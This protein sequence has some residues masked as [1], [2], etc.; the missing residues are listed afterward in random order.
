MA[1]RSID[2]NA[3]PAAATERPRKIA[4]I[5]SPSPSPAVKS[6]A[7]VLEQ[8]RHDSCTNDENSPIQPPLKPTE[9]SVEY[10]ASA[11]LKPLP[12][13][14]AKLKDLLIELESKDW[15][16]ACG[17]LND[18]RRFALYHSSL[19]L[20]ILEKVMAVIVKTMKSPRSALC[21]TSIMTCND[22]FSNLG[23]A[24]LSFG[25]EQE[26]AFDN[27]LL[28]LLLKASQDKR[29]VC[30]EAEKALEAMAMC[31]SPLPLLKKLQSFVT[32]SNLRVRAKAAVV[33]S[34]CATQM[35]HEAMKEFG[36]AT[37]LK[38]ASQSLN[39]RLP[40]AREA[41]RCVVNLIY[42]AFSSKI[43]SAKQDD[44]AS[45]SSTEELWEK[46]CF[47]NLSPVAAQSV[48]KIVLEKRG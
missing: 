18:V 45:E 40:E 23:Q 9:Q 28:Q 22:V 38:I 37:L 36:L 48:T 43:E 25:K 15:V 41:A 11:D 32:H 33:I 4:K 19:L 39:D 21:K 3:L 12:D 27:L 42:G 31:I 29:F 20:Q 2:D 7:A 44:G 8:L 26:L 17:A 6:K 34:K 1:L 35:E 47:S 24:L 13:P 14:Q 5:A 10:V 30:E 16:K 46:F